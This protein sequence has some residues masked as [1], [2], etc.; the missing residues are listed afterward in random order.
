MWLIEVSDTGTGI[1][2]EIIENIFEP[3]FTTKPVGQG[4]GPRSLDRLRHSQADRRLRLLLL[5][6]GQGH[7]LPHPAAAPRRDGGRKAAKAAE[8]IKAEQPQ[9]AGAPI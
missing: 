3:F 5:G 9:A 1:P 8:S 6:D 4:T 2:P 7:H